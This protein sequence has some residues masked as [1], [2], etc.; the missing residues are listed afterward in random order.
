MK[1]QND[2]YLTYRML[3]RIL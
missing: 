1:A 2:F 3:W